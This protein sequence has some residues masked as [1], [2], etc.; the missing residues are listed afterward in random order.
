MRNNEY[1]FFFEDPPNKIQNIPR[2]WRT[3]NC[4]KWLPNFRDHLLR[5]PSAGFDSAPSHRNMSGAEFQNIP[6]K[7]SSKNCA[8]WLFRVL[9]HF[10]YFTPAKSNS[11]HN[12]HNHASPTHALQSI[13]VRSRKWH[14]RM[15]KNE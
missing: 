13:K 12:G 6:R 4:A 3:K 10:L 14:K 2:N 9:T 5:D 11:Q 7:G 1:C 8:K 15:P